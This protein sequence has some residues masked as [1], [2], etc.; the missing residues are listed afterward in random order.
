MYFR[1]L[2]CHFVIYFT[3]FITKT[4]KKRVGCNVSKGSDVRVP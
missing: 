2:T 4:Q 3:V 1:Q